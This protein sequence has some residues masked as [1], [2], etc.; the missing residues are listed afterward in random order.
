VGD[1][2]R[3]APVDKLGVVVAMVLAATILGESTTINQW[4]GA[5]LIVGGAMLIAWR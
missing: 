4:I 1:V 3:V 2:A 5:A